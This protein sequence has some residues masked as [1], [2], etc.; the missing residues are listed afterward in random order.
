VYKINNHELEELLV[1]K[2]KRLRGDLKKLVTRSGRFYNE[3]SS[4]GYYQIFFSEGSNPVVDVLLEP[5]EIKKNIDEISEINFGFSAEEIID[6]LYLIEILL[7]VLDFN[8]S[9][10]H[11]LNTR[12]KD[13]CFDSIVNCP[14][15]N[16]KRG[17]NLSKKLFKDLLY[18]HPCSEEFSKKFFLNNGFIYY[19]SKAIDIHKLCEN[20]FTYIKNNKNYFDCLNNFSFNEMDAIEEL[21]FSLFSKMSLLRVNDAGIKAK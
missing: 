1:F 11:L 10:D 2:K 6:V 5:D 13:Y 14:Y 17:S 8:S 18:F 20:Y 4:S 3:K 16:M 21:L 7:T 15:K 12:S 19:Y 9:T